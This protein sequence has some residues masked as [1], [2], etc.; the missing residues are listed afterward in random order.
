[1]SF[2]LIYA[3]Q[4]K[5]HLESI[6]QKYHNL[7]RQTIESQLQFEPDRETRNRKPLQRPIELGADWEIRFGPENRFR[8]FYDVDHGNNQVN[9]IAIGVKRGN[10]VFIGNNEVKL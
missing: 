8:A 10:R 5:R 4:T 3:P 7:I 2:Q 6:E 9:I 1:M